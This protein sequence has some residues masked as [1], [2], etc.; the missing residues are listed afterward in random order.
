MHDIF[1]LKT[2]ENQKVILDRIIW[3]MFYCTLLIDSITGFFLLSGANAIYSQF[4]KFILIILICTRIRRRHQLIF[5][6]FLLLYVFFY[7]CYGAI[8]G[9]PNLQDTIMLF[10]KFS[11]SI[12]VYFYIKNALIQNNELTLCRLRNMFLINYIVV[13]INLI[14][15]PALGMGFRLYDGVNS[16]RGF[17]FAGN[18]LAATFVILFSFL[19]LQCKTKK[20]YSLLLLLSL[21]I[22]FS[23]PTKVAILGFLISILYITSKKTLFRLFFSLRNIVILIFFIGIAYYYFSNSG[24]L[25]RFQF[26]FEKNG[27]WFLLSGRDAYVVEKISA[28]VN[29]SFLIKCFGLGTNQTVEMDMFDVLLNFGYMGVIIIYSF[30]IYFIWQASK[31]QYLNFYARYVFRLLFCLGFISFLA[32][33]VIFSAMAG[34]FIGSVLALI[35]FPIPMRK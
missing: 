1:D 17:F 22:I 33:H 29:S 30:Y 32:G 16:S 26:F 11:I 28:F 23:F 24:L 18:E 21:M 27:W 14:I 3:F 31:N 12:L 10:S 25:E 9:M 8:I 4:Y 13:F 34:I 15:V 5:L 6:Y 7:Y 35:Y 2:R 19:L 20:Q